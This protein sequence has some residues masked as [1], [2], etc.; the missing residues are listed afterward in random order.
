MKPLVLLDVDGVV[1]SWDIRTYEQAE[2]A[3]AIVL[4]LV[5]PWP[6]VVRPGTVRALQAISERAES[7]LWCSSWRHEANALSPILNIEVSGVVTDGGSF[8]TDERG[9]AW[10]LKAV[11]KDKRVRHAQLEDRPVVWFE[12]FGWGGRFAHWSRHEVRRAGVI[13]IDTLPEGYLHMGHIVEA[14]L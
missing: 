3:G 2:A 6:V 8:A 5:K 12:D 11:T 7:I 10:K 4:P 14:G 9:A 13:G 1:N